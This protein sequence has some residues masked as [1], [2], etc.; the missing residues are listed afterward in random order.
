MRDCPSCGEEVNE[1][2][3]FCENCGQELDSTP[4]PPPAESEQETDQKNSKVPPPPPAESGQGPDQKHTKEKG[5]KIPDLKSKKGILGII[6]VIAII[7]ILI[8]AFSGSTG[9]YKIKIEYSGS[10]SGS[11]GSGTSQK[12]VSGTGD[13]TI[14]VD[15]ET[16]I[17]AVIQKG[18]GGSDKLTVKIMK[19]DEVVASKS[20]TAGYGVVDVST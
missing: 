13:D 8:V 2:A 1:D 17:V 19:G 10:W 14:D 12:S 6:A 5:L 15:D 20:T 11:V 4:P 16:P 9:G 3:T 18:G 7:F